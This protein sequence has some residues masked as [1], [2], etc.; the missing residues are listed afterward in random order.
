MNKRQYK[1]HIFGNIKA[2]SNVKL[3]FKRSYK[4]KYDAWRKRRWIWLNV[5]RKGK[6]QMLKFRPEKV[7][8]E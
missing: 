2:V 7:K 4:F 1:K 6:D 5:Y 8:G 3:Y